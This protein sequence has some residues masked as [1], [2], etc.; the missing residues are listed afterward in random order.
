[1]IKPAS[2]I[3][4]ILKQIESG[5]PQIWEEDLDGRGLE[6]MAFIKEIVFLRDGQ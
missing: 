5:G 4:E 3:L 1:M 6:Y 2:E